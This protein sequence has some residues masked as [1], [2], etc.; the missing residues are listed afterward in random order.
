M[1]K[2]IANKISNTKNVPMVVCVCVYS[3]PFHSR[4]CG[5][6][7]SL[8]SASPVPEEESKKKKPVKSVVYTM[9][10]VFCFFCQTRRVSLM[11]VAC[12]VV[13][14]GFHSFHPHSPFRKGGWPLLAFVCW[15]LFIV[16][17]SPCSLGFL[18]PSGGPISMVV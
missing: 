12:V 8:S 14:A 17:F 11:L 3:L 5:P 7:F 15:L 1:L 16:Y 13:V 2:N 6:F 10:V 4:C 18:F 9:S